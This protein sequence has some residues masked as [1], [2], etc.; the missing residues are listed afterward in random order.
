[1][2]NLDPIPLEEEEDLY[3]T[4]GNMLPL[5]K[6]RSLRQEASKESGTEETKKIYFCLTSKNEIKSVYYK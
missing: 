5:K 4:N 6:G 3:F 2:E 1:M